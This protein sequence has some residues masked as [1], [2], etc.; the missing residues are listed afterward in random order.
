MPMRAMNGRSMCIFAICA[1]RS[2][3]IRKIQPIS[4]LFMAWVTALLRIKRPRRPELFNGGTMRSLTVKLTLA[5]LVV[6]LTGA[7]LVA[8]LVG[9]RTRSE[10]NRFLSEHDQAALV[11]ALGGYYTD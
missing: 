5:F 10:F 2:N 4:R 1:Q 8:V 3:L 9:I 11:T 6:G 7:I